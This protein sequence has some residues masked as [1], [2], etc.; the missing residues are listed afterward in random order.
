MAQLIDE[1]LDLST[2]IDEVVMKKNRIIASNSD[3]RLIVRT[4]GSQGED[5]NLDF[6][7]IDGRFIA[8]FKNHKTDEWIQLPEINGIFVVRVV[9]KNWVLSQK[10]IGN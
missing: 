2:S 8:A 6:Y 10:I 5:I 3:G 4:S 9:G 7:E 1:N